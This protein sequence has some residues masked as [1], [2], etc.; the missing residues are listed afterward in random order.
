MTT[1]NKDG[2][3]AVGSRRKATCDPE[4]TGEAPPSQEA[5]MAEKN[6]TK[7]GRNAREPSYPPPTC[8]IPL[9]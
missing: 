8:R 6:G 4:P 9:Q 3:I 5:V 1:P 7:P 2:F